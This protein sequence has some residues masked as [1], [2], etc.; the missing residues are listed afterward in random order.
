M[1]GKLGAI[2]NCG[3]IFARE[4]REIT[5]KKEKK[6]INPRYTGMDTDLFNSDEEDK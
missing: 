5:R 3:R 2:R 4:K 1:V 6:E